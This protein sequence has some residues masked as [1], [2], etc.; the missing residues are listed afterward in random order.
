[1][2]LSPQFAS[3]CFGR[4][5]GGYSYLLSEGDGCIGSLELTVPGARYLFSESSYLL[6]SV[7]N[8]SFFLWGNEWSFIL[9][10]MIWVVVNVDW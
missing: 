7:C 10:K 2:I 8:V 1:M 3:I 4:N 6:I 9:F 5:K